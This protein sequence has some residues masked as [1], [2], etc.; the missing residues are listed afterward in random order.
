MVIYGKK[1]MEKDARRKVNFINGVLKWGK[2][3]KSGFESLGKS[4]WN[5]LGAVGTCWRIQ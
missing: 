3:V 4:V 2:V 5:H 1:Q